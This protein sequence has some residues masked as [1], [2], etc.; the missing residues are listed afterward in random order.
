[1]ALW[2]LLVLLLLQTTWPS[3]KPVLVQE[4]FLRSRLLLKGELVPEEQNLHAQARIVVDEEGFVESLKLRHGCRCT[5]ID[6]QAVINYLNTWRFRPFIVDGTPLK[7]EAEV[8]VLFNSM[9][10]QSILA[11]GEDFFLVD[12]ELYDREGLAE[13]LSRQDLQTGVRLIHVTFDP[14]AQDRI[15]TFLKEIGVTEFEVFSL[16]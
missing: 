16:D 6:R 11:L 8:H 5:G 14:D 13:L 9:P 2:P 3:E 12:E 10:G 15:A 4:S 1:M 7:M